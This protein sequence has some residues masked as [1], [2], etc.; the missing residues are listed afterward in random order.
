MQSLKE[1]FFGLSFW[2]VAIVAS[3][4]G[5]EL[6][7]LL[8]A[9]GRGIGGHVPGDPF[10]FGE[11]APVRDVLEEGAFIGN[12]AIAVVAAIAL[13]V[14]RNQLSEAGALRHAT[15][16]SSIE[17]RWSS[18]EMVNSRAEAA[19]ILFAHGAAGGL[20]PIHEFADDYLRALVRSDFEAYTRAMRIVDF[21]EYVGFLHQT[22]LIRLEELGLLLGGV[23][24]EVYSVF[25][26]HIESI[27]A[28]S[29]NRMG[30]GG[31]RLPADYLSFTGLVRE[32]RLLYRV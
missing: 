30:R 12:F 9:L 22:K 7:M 26:K 11:H 10:W 2:S 6:A 28:Q 13:I 31:Y 14:A 29:E 27:N 19:K 23:S 4:C 8:F 3:V 15:I 5:F 20:Q 25:Y 21:L 18:P 24:L 16:Y 32:F 1:P 17:E